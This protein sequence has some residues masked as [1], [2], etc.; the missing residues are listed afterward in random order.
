MAEV[1]ATRSQGQTEV[2]PAVIAVTEIAPVA[3]PL[4]LTG[5]GYGQAGWVGG[6]YATAFADGQARVMR[7]L[8]TAGSTRLRIG[9]GAWGG[10]QKF[11]ERLDIGPTIEAEFDTGAVVARLAVDYRVQVAGKASPGDGV[12]VTLSTGF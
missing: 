8:A 5:E 10:A 12:A 4:G 9:A 11:A 1:R 2:R 6:R 7:E 3:L